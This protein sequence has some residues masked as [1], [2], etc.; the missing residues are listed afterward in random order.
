M[1]SKGSVSKLMEQG[2]EDAFWQLYTRYVVE[3]AKLHRVVQRCL[4]SD[5]VGDPVDVVADSFR[6]VWE[7][8][9]AGELPR[10]EDRENL[11]ALLTAFAKRNA[12]A[13]ARR[14][15]AKGE[16]S[17]T[18][19]NTGP[20][21]LGDDDARPMNLSEADLRSASEGIE[22]RMAILPTDELRQVAQLAALG[23]TQTEIAELV[24]FN[25]TRQVQRAFDEIRS[26]WTQEPMDEF[27]QAWNE[28]QSPCFHKHFNSF[29][30]GGRWFLRDLA[31]VELHRRLANGMPATREDFRRR[32]GAEFESQ[33]DK[34]FEEEFFL[35]AFPN[36][37]AVEQLRPRLDDWSISVVDAKLAGKTN[38]EI[39]VDLKC[40]KSN[41]TDAMQHFRELCAQTG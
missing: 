21:R 1:K 27:Q 40:P 8:A 16:S 18:G 10:F 20:W 31:R 12:I 37:A 14:S 5:R 22:Q 34:L 23:K 41:I 38:Q 35:D 2:D 24:G 19:D 30:H 28:G 15:R 13:A 7:K 3:N 33:I 4:P 17:V 6:A 39:S 36:D 29:Q 9:E 32:A 11:L 26:R 25:T